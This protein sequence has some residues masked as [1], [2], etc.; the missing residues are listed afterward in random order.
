MH[1][2]YFQ[3]S[4]TLC[5]NVITIDYNNNRDKEMEMF[6]CFQLFSLIQYNR[7]VYDLSMTPFV[8]IANALR[9]AMIVM[10]SLQMNYR[11][12]LA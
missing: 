8:W 11:R 12:V 4:D 2:Y 1:I 7:H 10:F 5:M 6:L 3:Q 9:I